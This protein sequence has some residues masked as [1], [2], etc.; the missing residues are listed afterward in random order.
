MTDLF[1][2]LV[3]VALFLLGLIAGGVSNVTSGGAGAFTILVL[4]KYYSGL[5]IQQSIATVLAASTVMVLVGAFAFYRRKEVDGQLSLTIGL[6]GVIGAFIA[7]R[8]ASTVQSVLLGRAFGV[9][10]LFLALYASLEFIRVYRKKRSM[11]LISASANGG[12]ATTS[13]MPAEVYSRWRGRDV[14]AL[15]V[16]V[17][18]GIVIGFA[19]GLFGSGG[20]LT[21]GVLLIVFKLRT[22]LLL[23]T[24]LTSALFRY[25]GATVGYV[26]TSSIDPTIFLILAVGGAIGS[27]VG[28]RVVMSR[29]TKDSYIQIVI[30]GLFLFIS[31]EFLFK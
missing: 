2:S 9:F 5:T 31:Y 7:A 16:Q 24:S 23:G 4:D 1:N 14:K 25:A 29:R 8:F 20:G 6:S 18:L 30:V 26:T 17:S 21:I 22:R 13:Q 19:T 28:A 12:A 27:V 10:T 3:L 11:K 15:A